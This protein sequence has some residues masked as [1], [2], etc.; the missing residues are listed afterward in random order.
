MRKCQFLKTDEKG[1]ILSNT[2]DIHE[3]KPHFKLFSLLQNHQILPTL[4]LSSFKLFFFMDTKNKN[5]NFEK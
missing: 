2:K 4:I 1:D 5:K 3:E